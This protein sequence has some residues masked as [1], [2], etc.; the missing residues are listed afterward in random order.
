LLGELATHPS[1]K[2]KEGPFPDVRR[3]G[4]AFFFGEK[5]MRRLL[6]CFV[7]LAAY[8]C[9]GRSPSVVTSDHYK[10]TKGVMHLIGRYTIGHAC[11]CDGMIL[12][13]A[14]VAHPLYLRLGY[15]S[16]TILYS[17]SDDLGND[18]YTSS[19][20]LY[21]SRDLGELKVIAGTPSF[22]RHAELEPEPG[23]V[24]HW[25]E[26]DY[27]AKT[28][29]YAPIRREAHLVRNL[30]GHLIINKT[31]VRGASGSC[32]FNSEND[33][34][35]IVVWSV[36]VGVSDYIGIAVSISGPWWPGTQSK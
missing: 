22:Y 5:K 30:A 28:K 20:F 29:A 7:A 14:H 25:I 32:L 33:V 3:G 27:Q 8:A 21:L 17:W 2:A 18:G 6:I 10:N 13:A 11:P 31:P 4:A 34:V 35:G 23:S 19:A 16:E 26:Y 12:T 24:L 1:S 9:A 15:Q 36:R